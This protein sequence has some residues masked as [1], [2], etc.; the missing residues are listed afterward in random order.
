MNHGYLGGTF[1]PPHL[2][3]LCLAQ[4]ALEKFSLD[5]VFFIP[6][7]VPP[8]KTLA[9]I[10]SWEDRLKMLQLAC[11]TSPF[12]E[13]ADLE[14]P[15]QMSY[16]V[17]LLNRISSKEGRPW[18]IMGMDSLIDFRNWREPERILRIAEVLVG[19]RPGFDASSVPNRILSEV[20]LFEFPGVLASS[21]DLRDRVRSG[22]NISYLVTGSVEAYIRDRRLYGSEKGY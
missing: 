10:S 14:L 20:T 12:F 6:S 4:E 2:G 16:T 7:R 11:E 8:H 15:G 9:G 21:S 1:D 5:R 22:R 18:F 17:N 19:T 3:H 13:V